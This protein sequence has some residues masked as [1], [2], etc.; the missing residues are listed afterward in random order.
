[1][2]HPLQDLG[3][4]RTDRYL[5]RLGQGRLRAEALSSVDCD[6]PFMSNHEEH[7]TVHEHHHEQP[8]GH[9]GLFEPGPPL[10]TNRATAVS[11]SVTRTAS[12]RRGGGGA[13]GR[14][15]AA[16]TLNRLR[17]PPPRRAVSRPS[18]L[19]NRHFHVVASLGDRTNQVR[20]ARGCECRS[21]IEA[22]VP[23]RR[24][25][26]TSLAEWSAPRIRSVN[27]AMALRRQ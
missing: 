25:R 1:M 13:G 5:R 19:V 10:A 4:G 11:A 18:R 7:H 3:R 27:L 26:V 23:N 15:L 14:R 20:T 2:M 24:M 9:Y 17:H 16:V 8:S 6:R 22:G 21:A 12:G